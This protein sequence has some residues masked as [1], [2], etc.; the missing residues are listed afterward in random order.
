MVTEINWGNFRA[1]FNG[2]EQK[3]F[4]WLCSLLFYKE[5]GQPSGA[6]RYRN[7]A[8]IE[9]DPI[10]V[11]Q[12]VIGWQAKFL[13]SKI[14]E[15]KS[16][17]KTA[18]DNAKKENPTLNRIFFYLNVDFDPSGKSGVKDP[19][20]KIEIEQYAKAKG[21]SIT[22]RTAG[23][24]ETPF[25]CE[26]NATL[27]KHFFTLGEKSVIDFVT[28]I[29]RHT[30][31]I[32]D[33]I[34]SDITFN[35]KTIKIDRLPFT[36]VLKRTIAR[37]PLVVVS[38]EGGVGKTAVIKDLYNQIKETVPFFVF[39]ANEFNTSDVNELFR[40]YGSFTLSDLVEEYRDA[41]DKYIVIDS[42]EKLS[43]IERPEVF[44]EFLSTLR[45]AGWKI[46]FTT[47]LSYLDDLKNAFIQIYNVS[48]EP[49]IFPASQARNWLRFLLNMSSPCHKASA[50]RHFC[51][52]PF[53]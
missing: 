52:T 43:D 31:A 45:N 29:S 19:P 16:A 15:H 9:A 27:A 18:I 20:Y 22:W 21:V 17:L 25:V 42:A 34:R 5:H 1:K 3:T 53:I 41:N 4:E 7:Q 50:S 30:D 40:S 33:S 51:E 11:G 46:I 13:G 12:D 24:F 10:T 39:K 26:E 28:E 44:Q 37:S 36:K 2:K 32:L 35:D 8:G 23:F 6:L 47:R 49:T 38:G 48:F 14:S